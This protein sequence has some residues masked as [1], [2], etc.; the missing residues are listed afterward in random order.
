MQKKCSLKKITD[1]LY[2]GIDFS[3]LGII[4]YAICAA[5][6]TTVFLVAPIF[7]NTSFVRMGET[8]EAWIFFAVI[9]MANCKTPFE[10]AWKTFVFFLISQPLIYLFQVPFSWQGWGLFQYYRYWLVV[11]ILT[12][13][14]AFVGWYITR[15]NWLSVLIL[16]PVLVYLGIVAYNSAVQ[17][18]RHFPRLIF[19]VLFCLLQIAL[20]I[21]AFFRDHRKKIVGVAVPILAAVVLTFA[22][23][24]V[25]VNTAVYLPNSQ[26]LTES[27]VVQESDSSIHIAIERTGEDSMVRVQA[28]SFGGTEFTIQDG[29]AV[30]RY[31][32]DVYEDDGGHTQI[33]ITEI[34]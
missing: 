16:A 28:S 10:S 26:V 9:I 29:E 23:Q 13:P 21:T 6:L 1:K 19:T 14:A 20:Y 32:V 27:A 12:F 24:E 25:D 18:V 11:T 5:V 17:C 8:L 4:L 7:Q 33:R 2:G 22:T 31:A 34:S 15:K 3:W 30:Y